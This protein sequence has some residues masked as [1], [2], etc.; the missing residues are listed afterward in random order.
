MFVKSQKREERR[1]YVRLGSVFPVEFRVVS[2]DAKRFLSDW[3]QGFTNNISR[4][5]ICLMVNN[6]S[7]SIASLI[8][9]EQVKLSLDIEIPLFK[10]KV[11]AL[12]KVAWIN[13]TAK[14]PGRY[15]IGLAYEKIPP[16]EN[17]RIFRYALSKKLIPRIILLIAIILL[18]FFFVSS[19]LNLKLVKANQALVGQLL[20]ILQLS[21]LAK[22]NIKALNREKEE[23]NLKLSEAQTRYKNLQEDISKERTQELENLMRELESERLSLQDKLIAVQKK[24]NTVTEDLLRLDKRK[25]EL[26]KANVEKLYQ[27]LRVHQ[28]PRTGLIISFEGD[29]DINNWSF[30]YDLSLAGQVYLYFDDFAAARKIL[31][32]FNGGAKKNNGGF[33]NAYYADDG[34]PAEY[35]VHS[36]PN[37][38]V[39]ILVAHY[40]QDTQDKRYLDLAKGIADWVIKLQEQDKDGGLRGGPDTD[41]FSTE[42]NLDAYAFFNMLY[43]ITAEEKYKEAREKVLNWLKLHTY[44]RGDIP[45]IRGKGDSTIATDTY[46]WSIAA[47]GP[48]QLEELGMKPDKIIEFAENNCAVEIEYYRSAGE[49]VKVRGFDFVPGRNISRGG[50]VSPEWTAQM[51]LAYKIMAKF[52]HS[53]DMIAKARSYE[54]KADD[55]FSQISQLIIASPSPSGQG[56]GCLPYATQDNVDTGHGWFTPKGA[57]TGSVAGTAYAIFAYYG[58]NPLEL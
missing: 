53:K 55:Y 46:A 42:H 12:A 49:K 5:G 36:G 31:D 6:L 45:I 24:E 20:N 35:T 14:E 34:G 11:N 9:S 3:I 8:E 48:A 1:R 47:L 41:W 38:W 44:D 22:Q 33:L 23:L 28:N 43:K 15:L 37:I 58:Y 29:R 13:S 57:C 27:W 26:E 39:G 56:E 19:Y 4:G 30:I 2:L 32:F 40:I 54:Q 51:V 16:G 17:I 25:A 7:P 52:Y 21:G 50:V 10:R 18:L